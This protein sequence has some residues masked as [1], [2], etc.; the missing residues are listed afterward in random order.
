MFSKI[1]IFQKNHGNCR[2]LPGD[3]A[4]VPKTSFVYS[5]EGYISIHFAKI[6]VVLTNIFD[7]NI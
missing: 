2:Q 1:A 7:Y 4:L 5:H 6:A 3:F